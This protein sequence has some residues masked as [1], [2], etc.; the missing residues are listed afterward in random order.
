MIKNGLDLDLTPHVCEADIFG[1]RDSLGPKS[2]E[3]VVRNIEFSRVFDQAL[4]MVE[5]DLDHLEIL[6]DDAGINESRNVAVG[7]EDDATA[8]EI[9]DV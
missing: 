4:G 8:G 3:I 6:F 7:I 9:L 5:F 2:D 1:K